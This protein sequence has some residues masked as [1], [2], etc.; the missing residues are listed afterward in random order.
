MT[1]Q[2]REDLGRVGPPL[3]DA[4]GTGARASLSLTVGSTPRA[5]R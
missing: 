4:L 1:T 3:V 2:L 5:L